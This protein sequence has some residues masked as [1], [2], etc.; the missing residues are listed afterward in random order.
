MKIGVIGTGYVGLVSAVGL[1]ELGHTV[2]G[3]DVDRDKIEKAS[4]GIP[5]IFEP[6]LGD[7]LRSNLEKGNL[8]FSHDLEETIRT[9]DVLF[10]CVNT[11]QKE[12]GSADMSYI[13]AVSRK[14]AENL[15]RYKL[16]VEKSTVPV[17]TSLWI[18][19]TIAL[20]KK[21]DV[22]FDVASNPEFLRE[23]SAVSDF[24]MVHP[25]SLC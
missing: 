24:L 18:K 4:Q 9:C 6:G 14:I 23:G 22:P 20:Y 15:D 3:T 19:R 2:V 11:P 17:K 10:V 16:A 5:S 1:A 13:E 21:K 12:D 7:L 25:Q 8:N